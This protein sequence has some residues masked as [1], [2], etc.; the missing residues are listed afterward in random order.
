MRR[1][2]QVLG[3]AV[4]ALAALLF[5]CQTVEQPYRYY[6]SYDPELHGGMWVPDIFP[7]DITEI[8]EQ[9]DIDTNEVWLR[10]S[11]GE[12]TFQPID[13]GYSAVDTSE[14]GLEARKPLW[15]PWRGRWWYQDLSGSFQ[16]YRGSHLEGTAYLAIDPDGTVYWW[17]GAA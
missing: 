9:H 15:V 11:L 16:L 7:H 5:G 3:V 4:A 12:A 8:H 6:E 10:F 13:S 14:T 1:V 2:I 17:R